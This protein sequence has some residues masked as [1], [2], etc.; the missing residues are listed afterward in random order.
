[1]NQ[2]EMARLL[3]AERDLPAARKQILKEHLMTELRRAD[4]QP[5]QPGQPGL[6]GTTRPRTR[7][8]CSL[9]ANGPMTPRRA[10]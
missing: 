9:S 2:D 3:P 7:R 1:M 8:P 6:P 5:A 10:S 4:A